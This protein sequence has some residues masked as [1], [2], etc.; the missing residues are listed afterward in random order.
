MNFNLNI[1]VAGEKVRWLLTW[2]LCNYWDTFY[3]WLQSVPSPPV[4][5][6]SSGDWRRVRQSCHLLVKV[7]G[8]PRLTVSPL[9]TYPHWTGLEDHTIHWSNSILCYFEN[10]I[11]F[12]EAVQN[13]NSLN[14]EFLMILSFRLFS[15]LREFR[16]KTRRPINLVSSVT[17]V[18][19]RP[20]SSKQWVFT[21][22]LQSQ[23]SNSSEHINALSSN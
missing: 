1:S 21:F 9:R 7:G 5:S 23:A 11:L 10:L 15:K 8:P 12:E 17:I 20:T 19:Q 14:T 2:Y 3:T 22:I 16:L 4:S 6:L 13:T 18:N